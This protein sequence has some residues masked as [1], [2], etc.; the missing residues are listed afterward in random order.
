MF[1]SKHLFY[2]AC[3]YQR[4]CIHPVCQRE[5]RDPKHLWYPGGPSLWFVPIPIPD[6]LRPY[7]RQCSACEGVCAG[8]YIKADKL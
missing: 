5:R 7:G 1:P 6:P 4:G 2:L 3:C 8:H